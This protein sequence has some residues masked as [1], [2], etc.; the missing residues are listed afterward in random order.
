[1][2]AVAPPAAETTGL[3]Q[4]G[5]D[6]PALPCRC[7]ATV[8]FHSPEDALAVYNSLVADKELRPDQVG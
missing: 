6:Q 3:Q 5:T 4:Q 7:H 2:T 1:M 8:D